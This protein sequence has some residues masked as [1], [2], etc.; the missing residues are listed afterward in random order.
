MTE[1]QQKAINASGALKKID[2]VYYPAR[3]GR[4]IPLRVKVLMDVKTDLL[5]FNIPGN[6][7][8]EVK[9]GTEY[10][11]MVNSYGA[12]T[13]LFEDGTGLG[14]KPGEFEVIEFHP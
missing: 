12:V 5:F 7:E 8:M 3:Y 13:A 1:A 10:Y 6:P 14:L 11:V 2:S 9:R 4:K